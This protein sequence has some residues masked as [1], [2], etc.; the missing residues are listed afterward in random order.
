MTDKLQVHNERRRHD[1]SAAA[2]LMRL[3]EEESWLR[4]G[5]EGLLGNKVHLIQILCSRVTCAASSLRKRRRRK[6][7][8]EGVRGD[9]FLLLGLSLETVLDRSAA[10]VL[11]EVGLTMCLQLRV[12]ST[13]PGAAGRVTPESPCRGR[14][15][16]K[17]QQPHTKCNVNT[18][19]CRPH[20]PTY[21]RCFITTELYFSLKTVRYATAGGAN[22]GFLCSSS[23]FKRSDQVKC[24]FIDK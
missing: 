9:F 3:K 10:A 4:S 8:S 6:K 24:I 1:I 19:V 15:I 7:V 12:Q 11:H 18:V 17:P 5:S 13:R 2:A 16:L 22:S 20:P 23:G 14:R 21:P